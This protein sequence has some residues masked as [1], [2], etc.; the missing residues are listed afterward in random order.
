MQNIDW[1]E[2]KSE[3]EV[4]KGMQY[5]HKGFSKKFAVKCHSEM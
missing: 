3:W 2:S 4:R 5:M 1:D